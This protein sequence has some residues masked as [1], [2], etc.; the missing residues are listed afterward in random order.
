MRIVIA[1]GN[2]EVDY[3][4]KMFMKNHHH[5]IVINSDREFCER[6]SAANGLGVFYGDPSKKYILEDS[7][8]DGA[9]VL[10]A[11]SDNDADNL[12]ICQLAKR[13]FHVKRAIAVVSNPKNVKIF[14]KLGINNAISSTHLIAQT[15]E[16]LSIVE[17]LVRTLS[18]EDEKIV[19]T[20]VKIPDDSHI[21][22]QTLKE[23]ENPVNF[24]ISCIFREPEVIIPNGSTKVLAGDKLVIISTPVDQDRI[25]EFIQRKQG[26]V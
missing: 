18:I 3:L 7:E 9:D 15:I 23:M 19:L 13:I 21:I 14:M 4:I 11:L 26:N 2:S 10:I 6:L 5:L 24:I 1:G 17:N 16:R 20:E 25:V 8:V 22:G 12:V